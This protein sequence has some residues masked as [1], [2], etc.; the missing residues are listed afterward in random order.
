M[1]SEALTAL[2]ATGGAAVVQAAGTDAWTGF[3]AKVAGWFGRGNAERERAEL[4][5]LDRTA[6]A[7]ADGSGGDL[8]R[9][10]EQVAWETRFEALLESAA[11]ER[12]RDALAGRLRDLLREPVAGGP[13]VGGDVTLRADRGSVAAVVVN[14][15]VRVDNTAPR[16]P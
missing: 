11:D 4:E 7:L 13:V 14:G 8:V 6:A 2:A 16:R 3:R 1:L 15:G 5:R 9:V 12:E 10:R